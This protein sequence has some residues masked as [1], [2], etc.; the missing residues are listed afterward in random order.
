MSALVTCPNASQDAQHE[1]TVSGSSTT[2]TFDVNDEQRPFDANFTSTRT[3]LTPPTATPRVESA[4]SAPRW[5]PQNQHSLHQSFQHQDASKSTQSGAAAT[6]PTEKE[7]MTDC[8]QLVSPNI[9]ISALAVV[10][11]TDSSMVTLD[12]NTTLVQMTSTTRMAAHHVE[13][14]ANVEPARQ[15][16]QQST[17]QHQPLSPIPFPTSLA[18]SDSPTVLTACVPLAGSPLVEEICAEG[19]CIC[20]AVIK[21]I[22]MGESCSSICSSFGLT[23]I[24]R[25]GD[26]R[27][28]NRCQHFFDND[29][30]EQCDDTIGDPVSDND[31]VCV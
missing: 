30:L 2:I 1:T 20:A 10:I 28:P 8:R 25:H 21:P 26:A 24:R 9:N 12:A 3:I 7:R 29:R 16:L 22:M 18:P 31:D 13:H 14:A 23:C 4:L 17:T 19:T 27:A 6:L 5:S 15:Q 11:V